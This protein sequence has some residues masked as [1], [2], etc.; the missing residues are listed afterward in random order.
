[1]WLYAGT[2]EYP[3]LLAD[4]AVKMLQ[5]QKI[6]R[7]GSDME[8]YSSSR[9]LRGHTPQTVE[10]NR[11]LCYNVDKLVNTLV[12]E[13]Y[14]MWSRNASQC[15]ECSTQE[16]PHMAKGLC[17]A[18]YHQQ[19]AERN[20]EKLR[21]I[22]SRWYVTKV[23]G[24]DRKK[25][26]RERDNY[27]S[28]REPVLKRDNYLCV[29]CGTDTGLI[30]HHEDRQGRGWD[31]PDNDLDNLMT[32]CRRCHRLEHHPEIMAGKRGEFIPPIKTAKKRVYETSGR[33][34]KR[35]TECIEC[36]TT[37]IKHKGHGLCQS[38]TSRAWRASHR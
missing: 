38:C 26:A 36:G 29:T 9:T 37:E 15:R 33:W 22:K 4:K 3:E 20:P 16:I 30:V 19:Y 23:Q 35:Y 12:E 28:M 6:S 11:N 8:S 24:T 17:K 21:G 32:L 25:S 18:C 2:S 31:E 14:Q 13:N 10:F 1:M 34:S 5:V 7:E 27:D